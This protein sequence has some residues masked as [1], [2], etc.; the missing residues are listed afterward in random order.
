MA[1]DPT[2][3]ME[4]LLDQ[5]ERNGISL[6]ELVAHR[7]S[8]AGRATWGDV[9]QDAIDAITTARTLETVR[10]YVEFLVHGDDAEV[11]ICACRACDRSEH[12]GEDRCR[13]RFE[14]LAGTALAAT[15]PDDITHAARVRAAIARNG[16]RGGDGSGA[17]V[18]VH[19]AAR[20]VIKVA[21]AKKVLLFDPLAGLRNPRRVTQRP[22]RSFEPETFA[23]IVE[24]FCLGGDDPE[25]DGLLAVF[26]IETGA[27]SGAAVNL[28]CSGLLDDSCRIR[29]REKRGRWVDKPVSRWLMD[30][31]TAHVAE[32][33]DPAA[34]PDGPVFHYRPDRPYRHFD[35]TKWE[36]RTGYHSVGRSRFETIIRRIHRAVPAAAEAGFRLHDLRHHVASVVERVFGHAAAEAYL[37]HQPDNP[38]SLYTLSRNSEVDRH[39]RWLVGE[40]EDEG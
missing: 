27:R 39:H 23:D 20:H 6:E 2:T 4:F 12:C 3:Q 19:G 26:R 22:A 31:L 34:G 13:T 28:R 25:L 32:R 9:R 16:P 37:N 17:A 11:C 29:F 40:D 15:T 5:I 7:D 33:G 10:T 36:M 18:H 21:L 1:L 14:G 24:E 30:T 8:G 35:G 38:T